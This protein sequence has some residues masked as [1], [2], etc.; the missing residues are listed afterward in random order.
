MS[1]GFAKTCHRDAE[2][3]AVFGYRTARHIYPLFCQF[4]M[5]LLVAERFLLRFRVYEFLDGGLHLAIG[6]RLLPF[7]FTLLLADGIGEEEAERKNTVRSLGI[8]ILSGA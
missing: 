3:V 6:E 4:L 8:L 5:N 7:L 2:T 1:E